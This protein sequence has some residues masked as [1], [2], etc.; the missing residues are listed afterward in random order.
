[1]SPTER[2]RA[3]Q[4]ALLGNREISRKFDLRFPREWL[5][6]AFLA[7]SYTSTLEEYFRK[8]KFVPYL[9]SIISSLE[10]QFSAAGKTVF[11][12]FLALSKAHYANGRARI[13]ETC[14]KCEDAV[15]IEN[16]EAEG[17]TVSECEEK[18]KNYTPDMENFTE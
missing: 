1:M 14:R 9:D 18:N 8:S 12:H 2:R 10:I 4:R 6:Q 11:Q 13:H 3:I 15:H 5:R 17:A 7:N 16:L